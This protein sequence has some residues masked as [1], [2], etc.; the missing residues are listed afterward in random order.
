ML[1]FQDWFPAVFT[2]TMFLTFGVLKLIGLRKGV[3]GGAGQSLG[4]RLCG[5]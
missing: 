5:T 4:R 3:V 2:G 1:R